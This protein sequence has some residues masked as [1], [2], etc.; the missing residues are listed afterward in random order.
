MT[1]N[2]GQVECVE[3]DTCGS[4]KQLGLKANAKRYQIPHLLSISTFSPGNRG[5]HVGI[6]R[7]DTQGIAYEG[8]APRHSI[9]NLRDQDKGDKYPLPE[10][11]PKGSFN[12]K[13]S[14]TELC[15]L[16]VTE[17]EVC[18]FAHRVHVPFPF[19]FNLVGEISS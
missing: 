11:W 5:H 7:L 15:E 16:M 12:S 19:I 18:T 9:P 6:V 13:K 3:K 8:A 17:S 1:S 2:Q 4:E 10:L 14:E